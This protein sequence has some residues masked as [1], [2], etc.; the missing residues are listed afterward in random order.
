MNRRQFIGTLA[1]AGATLAA[2]RAIAGHGVQYEGKPVKRSVEDKPVVLEVAI[3][4]STTKAKNK[5]VPVTPQE[6]GAEAI[7]VFDAGATI[8]HAH[9]QQPNENVQEAARVYIEAFKPSNA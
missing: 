6:I 3:N 9:S 5:N 1:V 8:V 2:G 7:R 4:G